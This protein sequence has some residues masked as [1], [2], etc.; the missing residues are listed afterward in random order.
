MEMLLD[1]F[2]K[3]VMVHNNAFFINDDETHYLFVPVNIGKTKL[4]YGASVYNDEFISKAINTELSLVSV[5]CEDKVYIVDEIFLRLWKYKE[6]RNKLPE[7]VEQFSS[8][9]KAVNTYA[10][11]KLFN[12]FYEK[13]DI[14]NVS[15]ISVKDEVRE[16][17][18]SLKPEMSGVKHRTMFT[19]SD[20]L[21]FMSGCTDIHEEANQIFEKENWI[22]TKSRRAKMEEMIK[23]QNGVE[24][25]E[26]EILEGLRSVPDAKSV[27]V[28]FDFNGKTAGEKV[29]PKTIVNI[30]R[31]KSYFSSYNF[32]NSKK[33]TRLLKELNAD[34]W[35][36]D[37]NCLKC[38]N[39][40]GI[41]YGKKKLYEKNKEE[42]SD[43]RLSDR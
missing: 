23:N 40:I 38:E 34:D 7:C 18:F 9:V 25:W 37:N 3:E 33:G 11:G 42:T 15:E 31:E 1:K 32:C 8:A 24:A 13:L 5:V 36:S 16:I 28:V 2:V 35:C 22:E 29:C 43:G 14:E 26:R 12:E 19:E 30:L 10:T 6:N 27:N 41:V 17:L 39:I 21:K 4:V 20:V